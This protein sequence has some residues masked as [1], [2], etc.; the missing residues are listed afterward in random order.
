VTT[1]LRAQ[2]LRHSYG[3]LQV[4]SGLDLHLSAGEVLG[5]LGPNGAGKSTT[6]AILAGQLRPDAGT[7]HLEERCMDGLP[8]W[9]RVRAGLG[10]LA[11]EPTVIRAMTVADNIGLIG[12]GVDVSACLAAAGL[13]ER[14]GAMA[15]TLSGGER[16]RL[17]IARSLAT[18]PRVMLMDEP[19]SGVDPVGVEDLKR[20]IRELAADGL[21]V[22]LTDHAVRAALL[23]CDRVVL[24]DR[25]Q[26]M[27]H[28]T[29]AEVAADA[30]VRDRYLGS[31][32][33]AG[34]AT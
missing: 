29:P 14:A 21:G 25:G 30:R 9:R 23:C 24:L 28:G 12:P 11:Q 1:L 8:L 27:A 17:E 26:V 10:Y 33:D 4:L 3:G 6:F 13:S 32:F 19:F 22:L 16:R 2:G 5:L 34:P 7:V 15:G 31:E 20:I 18:G